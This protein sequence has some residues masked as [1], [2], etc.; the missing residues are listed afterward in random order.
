MAT[1]EIDTDELERKLKAYPDE[2]EKRA[3]FAV[4]ATVRKVQDTARLH[5]PEDTLNLKGSI[6][7]ETDGLEGETFTVVEYARIQEFGGTTPNGGDIKGKHYMQQG[8]DENKPLFREQ[9][10][11]AIRLTG[12]EVSNS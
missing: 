6:T 9:V 10:A 1:I 5:A 4:E 8:A 12:E 11:A 7:I 3:G 2:M